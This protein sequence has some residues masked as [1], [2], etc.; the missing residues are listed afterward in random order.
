[1]I[2]ATTEDKTADYSGISTCNP[3]R[4]ITCNKII[5]PV[6]ISACLLAMSFAGV[7]T[8]QAAG[9][10]ETGSQKVIL[11]LWRIPSKSTTW[12]PDMANRKV[13][14][15]FCRKYPEIDVR[16]LVPLKIEGPAAEGNEFLAVAGGVAPDVF[17]LY[18]R[19]I[20]DY[21]GQGFL[22]PLDDF[23]TQYQKKN[24]RLYS[25]VAAP[26]PVWEVCHINGH[27][28]CVPLS[29]YSFALL[30]RRDLFAQADVPLQSP[31]NWDEFYR[32]AR[33]LTR[34]PDKEPDSKPGDLNT[35]GM[36]VPTG[37]SAGWYMMQYFWSSGGDV[38][39]SFYTTENG[40]E[41]E[42][43]A[44][45][46]NYRNWR[47]AISDNKAYYPR[48]QKLRDKLSAQGI[49][50][51]Y[52]I[53]DLKWR[54]ATD[55]EAGLETLKFIRRLVHQPWIRCGN[56]EFDLTP[57]MLQAGKAVC[58]DCGK[59][60]DLTS[61]EV[62]RRIYHGVAYTGQQSQ[63]QI[64]VQ[65][66]ISMGTL[67]ETMTFDPTLIAPLTFPSR[68]E[69][70]P[71]A[72]YIAAH[73][74]AINATQTDPKVREAAWKYIEFM[75]GLEAQRL[76][77]Q[78]YAEGGLAEFVR[79]SSLKE[80]GLQDEL[81][82]IPPER[83]K[84]WEILEEYARP[85]PYCKGFQHVMT[86]EM[87]IIM[88]AIMSDAPDKKSDYTYT[89]DLQ[90]VMDKTCH[91]VNTQILGQMPEEEVRK[92]AR[93]GWFVAVAAMAMLAA[94]A[95]GTVKMAIRLH[96]KAATLEGYGVKDKTTMRTLT[97]VLFLA[98]AIG[99]IL[100]WGYYPLV[101]G[102]LIAF[103][104]F[105]I[106]G[107][108]H[109]VGL[110]NF[111][112]VCSSKEFWKYLLHTLQY[113]GL[114][115]AMGFFAPIILAIL[116]T[117]IPKGK[118]LYRTLYYL[119]AVTTGIVTLFMWKQLLYDSSSSGLINSMILSCNDL[120]AP[121]MI[122][123]KGII[124]AALLL[125]LA[126]TIR[127]GLRRDVEKLGRIIPLAI[128]VMI[129]TYLGWKGHE[130]F[131]EFGF[132]G[133]HQWWIEPWSFKPQRFLQD[134]ELAMFWIIVPTVWSGMGPGCLIY[135]AAL[136]GIPEEQYEAADMDGAGIWAKCVN[137]IYPNLSALIQINLVG[138][139]VGAMHASQN[140]FIMTGGGPED[141]TMTV[142]LSVWFNA[143]MY[144]NFGFATAQA[145]I[146]GMMLIGFTLYQLRL[147]NKMQF[148][149][150]ATKEIR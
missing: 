94:A 80:I 36:Y 47:I 117:E 7:S 111:I 22:N 21:Y 77:A 109:Y 125:I 17:Y 68:T 50:P 43:P 34:L 58:P 134:R 145:W 19:K 49:N 59:V 70:I 119:P 61:P 74:L 55:D 39:K 44:P 72:A 149:A 56:V 118:I 1:M 75:T 92:R 71:P 12:L 116:L 57:E 28:Y 33:R 48:M 100:M 108:S 76:R 16:P 148:R 103:Q 25:G 141:A 82:R 98:P 85:E 136:K 14:D 4:L 150:A 142:G 93:V 121:M 6:V 9:K 62:Q 130:I 147:L 107:D 96:A 140:I 45:L 87:S 37:T 86:R 113:V 137:V 127:I 5:K 8:C 26:S 31:R 97:V 18:G 139:V 128:A 53:T 124:A 52:N 60:F 41:I 29:Y 13:F 42:V 35:Y 51:D 146:L 112:E 15:A 79:P 81:E 144:L 102:T 83:R 101:R 46:V 84:L 40:N 66:A 133:F 104:D 73:Y 67:W 38:V 69:D 10:E 143:Y 105:K 32:I 99:T 23:L 120:S 138:A 24:G 123:L 110:R 131:Q 129:A 91:R 27:I 90:Q 114:S 115:L 54:L 2:K 135:L 11:R 132:A 89:R 78:V 122:V 3:V 65:M 20:G 88:D 30:A 95:Y 106:L 126:G 63:K 64:P